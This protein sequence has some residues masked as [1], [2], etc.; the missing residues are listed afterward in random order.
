MSEYLM[1]PISIVMI[2]GGQ[3]LNNYVNLTD[4]TQSDS[5]MANVPID[6]NVM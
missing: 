2:F 3:L 1:R 4:I 6:Q 5:Q